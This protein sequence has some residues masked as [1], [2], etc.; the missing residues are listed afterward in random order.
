MRIQK[1][2][3]WS[4]RRHWK[5]LMIPSTRSNFNNNFS[6]DLKLYFTVKMPEILFFFLFVPIVAFERKFVNKICCFVCWGAGKSE[7]IFSFLSTKAV[8]ESNKKWKKKKISSKLFTSKWAWHSARKKINFSSGTEK[9]TH[10]IFISQ[11]MKQ[12]IFDKKLILQFPSAWIFRIECVS[13]E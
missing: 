5:A 6:P 10:W 3:F 8:I 9:K 4:F 12:E 1:F 7:K 2:N 11:T 13:Y